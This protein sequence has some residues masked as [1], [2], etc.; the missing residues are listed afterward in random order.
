MKYILIFFLGAVLITGCAVDSTKSNGNASNDKNLAEVAVKSNKPSFVGDEKAIALANQ[1]L[2]ASGGQAGWDKTDYLQWNFFG[3]RKH[4]WNK[5]TGDLIIKGIRDTFETRMNLN[6]LTGTVNLK[7]MELTHPDSLEK[8][9]LKA[10]D[11]WR[12]DSYWIFLPFKLKDPGVRLSHAGVG[13]LDSIVGCEKLEMTFESVG[14]TPDNKYVLWVHPE[15]KHIIQWDFYPKA[16]D[17]EPRF[18]TPWTNYQKFDDIWLS[19]Q[20]GGDY[21][22]SEIAVGEKLAVQFE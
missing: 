20:R 9:I 1:V 13:D 10:R 7:G 2:A 16:D 4:V 3:S 15:T 17:E 18:V 8:Y 21:L 12:N 14:K 11:M 5:S 22:I 19:D 6:D